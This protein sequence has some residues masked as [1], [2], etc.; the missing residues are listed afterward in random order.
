MYSGMIRVHYPLEKERIVLRTEKDW[1]TDI[2]PDRIDRENHTWEFTI[3]HKHNCIVYKPCIR[4]GS[5]IRWEDGSNRVTLL[6]GETI[7]DIYPKFVPGTTGSITQIYKVA[8]KVLKRDVLLRLYL[9]AGYEDNPLM[10]YPTIYMH[11]GKNL[12]FPQEAF[13]GREWTV[14]E[15]LDLLNK[16]SLIEQTI[17]VGVYAEDREYEYTKPGY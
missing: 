14:D 9:P 7:E 15:N 11:D 13:L 4:D 1:E 16:M 8:S 6:D 2:E 10:Y 17:V 5:D 12:F 3:T